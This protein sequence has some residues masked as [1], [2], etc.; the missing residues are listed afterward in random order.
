MQYF[1]FSLLT[2]PF[3]WINYKIIISDLKE[4]KIPNKLL[5][6]LIL[7]LPFFYWFLLFSDIHINILN[8]ILQIFLS[9]IISFILYYFWI[10][11]AWDAK[12]LLVLSLFIPQIWIIP[13]IWNIAIITLIYLIWYFLWFY[14]WKCLFNWKYTKSLYFNIYTD[15]KDKSV[16]FLKHWDW[17]FYKKIIFFKILKW[18]LLFLIFFVSIRLARLYLISD[19]VNSQ[20]YNNFKELFFIYSTYFILIFILI[21]FAIFYLIRLTI[22]KIKDFLAKK[23]GIKKENFL[24]DFVLIW[25]LFSILMSFIIYEYI[26]NPSE[27]KIYLIRIFTLYT[28]IYRIFKI[29][30]Y[31]YKITFQIAETYYV[32][33]D[34]LKEWDI[35]DREY[36]LKMFWEQ[37]CL[38]AYE[39]DWILSPNP[40]KYFQNLEN[41]IDKETKN[42]LIKIYKIVNKYHKENTK[43]YEYLYKIKILQTFAFGW[44]IFIWFLVS[45]LLWNLIFEF[46][47]KNIFN[48]FK[49]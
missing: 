10:W 28:G 33:V 26:I 36:L 37:A 15:L 32:N 13:F 1:L 2:I 38:W 19:I 25:I 14:F 47:L 3:L 24:I 17:N 43:N 31:T 21:F 34:N 12:Y 7:I 6:Y 39:H 18:L 48:I 5:L 30:K 23:I 41:P 45:F 9:L 16:T 22:N 11:S 42:K 8:F 35:V 29:L 40:A 44:Y 49:S 46:L 4:K 27:I 20:Y